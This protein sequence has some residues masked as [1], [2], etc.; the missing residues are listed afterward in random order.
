[1]HELLSSSTFSYGI[2]VENELD[3]IYSE[4]YLSERLY[5]KLLTPFKGITFDC[6]I[7]GMFS[8]NL[9]AL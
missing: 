5:I 8:L 4:V 2:S 3:C 9:Q 6:K 1:M 7:N